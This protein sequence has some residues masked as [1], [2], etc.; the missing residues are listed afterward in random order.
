[1]TALLPMVVAGVAALTPAHAAQ[2]ND[3]GYQFAR[4]LALAG[5]RPAG[6]PAERRAH[7]RV[8]SRFRAA[9]LRVGTDAFAVPG[10]GRSRATSSACSTP[11]PTAWSSCSPTSTP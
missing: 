9:G 4:S 10:H 8:A 3:P 11:P 1:M 6:S 2:T 7:D 5:P